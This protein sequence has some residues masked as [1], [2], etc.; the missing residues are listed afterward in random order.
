M[1]DEDGDGVNCVV[2]AVSCLTGFMAVSGKDDER[3]EEF[4]CI[5]IFIM[6]SLFFLA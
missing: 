4:I 5:I 3:V 1:F 6:L 2:L